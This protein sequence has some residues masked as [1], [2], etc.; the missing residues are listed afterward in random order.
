MAMRGHTIPVLLLILVSSSAALALPY[1]SPLLDGH[2]T[3]GGS[4]GGEDW[5]S[6]EWAVDDSPYDNRWGSNDPDLDDLYVTWDFYALYFGITTDNVPSVYGNGYLLFID[7]DAQSGITG[8]TDL[9]DCDFYPQRITFSTM[10]VDVMYGVW[11]LD[12]TTQDIKHCSDPTSTTSIDESYMVSDQWWRHIEVAVS[13]NGLYALGDGTVP[14][15]TKLRFIAAVVG[16]P[17]SGA[18]D[19]MPNSSTGFETDP[20][21]PWDAYTDLDVYYEVVVDGDGDG[22]PDAGVTPVGAASWGRIKSMFVR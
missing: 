9:T 3:V 22:V 16:G 21:N 4:A 7:T 19:A 20:S 5:E 2:V 6:D 12:A 14:P 8:A 10:G 13:W 1:N 18:Y 11:N 15:G 17:T